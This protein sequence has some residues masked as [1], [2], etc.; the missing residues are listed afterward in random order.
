MSRGLCCE[1]S[2][3]GLTVWWAVFSGDAR[4]QLACE[5]SAVPAGQSPLPEPVERGVEA[6]RLQEQLRVPRNGRL[7]GGAG[8]RCAPFPA[9]ERCFCLRRLDGARTRAGSGWMASAAFPNPHGFFFPPHPLTHCPE[10]CADPVLI[11]RR[12][13]WS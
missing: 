13:G 3:K 9:G 8:G 6:S 10:D 11:P 4:W 5:Q 12:T 2:V 1:L 7:S